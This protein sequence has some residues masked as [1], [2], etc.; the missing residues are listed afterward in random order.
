M[1]SAYSEEVPGI[2]P[3]LARGKTK[4]PVCS[5]THAASLRRHLL[6]GEASHATK[7][8]RGHVNMYTP[9]QGNWILLCHGSLH[10]NLGFNFA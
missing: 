1:V 7:D 9:M 8:P 4:K 6:A 10:F 2:E 3:S 5:H